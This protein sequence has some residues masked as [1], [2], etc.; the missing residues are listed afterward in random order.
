MKKISKEILFKKE[1]KEFQR[2]SIL[3]GYNFGYILIRNWSGDTIR[4]G[5]NP[6]TV[7]NGIEFAL[8]LLNAI[9]Y[10]VMEMQPFNALWCS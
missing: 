9:K 10:F 5:S 8:N 3:S 2:Y 1:N 7:S 4:V 6:Y